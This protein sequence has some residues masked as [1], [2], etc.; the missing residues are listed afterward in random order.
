MTHKACVSKN[1]VKHDNL[2]RISYYKEC[3][4]LLPDQCA[5]RWTMWCR[6]TDADKKL[7]LC[8]SVPRSAWQRAS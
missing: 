3:V 5:S 4:W 2:F 6:C 8:F 1:K 7:V